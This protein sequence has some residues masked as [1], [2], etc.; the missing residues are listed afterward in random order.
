[1]ANGEAIAEE[2]EVRR[3]SFL[4]AYRVAGDLRKACVQIGVARQTISH[5]K[6]RDEEFAQEVQL[7]RDRHSVDR[8]VV[9]MEATQ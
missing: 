7:I 5:W 4:D 3:T 1:M 6:A 8:L 9:A 2:A